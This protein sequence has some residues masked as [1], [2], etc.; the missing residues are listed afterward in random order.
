MA[1]NNCFPFVDSSLESQKVCFE[2]KSPP[3]INFSPRVSISV[4]KALI[5][6]ACLGDAINCRNNAFGDLFS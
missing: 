3:V 5:L 6:I 1:F 2:I 4:Y